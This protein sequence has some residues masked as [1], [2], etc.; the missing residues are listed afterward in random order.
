MWPAVWRTG[1]VLMMPF[2]LF[3]STVFDPV[4]SYKIMYGVTRMVS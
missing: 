1:V 2:F 3:L 4:V